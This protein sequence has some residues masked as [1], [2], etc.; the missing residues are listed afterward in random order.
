VTTLSSHAGNVATELVLAVARQGAAADRQGV[1]TGR[2]GAA[3]DCQGAAEQQC[4]FHRF[5]P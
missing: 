4:R 1:V 3:V 5:S 2:Q